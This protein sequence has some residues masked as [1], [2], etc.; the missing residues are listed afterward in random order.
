MKTVILAEKP[1]Q[2]RAYVD[3]M[4]QSE[5]GD[6]FYTVTDPVLNG[7]ATITYGFGHLVAL[8]DQVLM[9]NNTQSGIWLSSHCFL[10]NTNLWCRMIKRNNLIS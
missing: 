10:T 9:V 1:S 7:T 4:T 3:A 2:A 8:A 6:G 5:R